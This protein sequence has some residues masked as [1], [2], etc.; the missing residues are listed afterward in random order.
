MRSDAAGRRCGP[1]GRSLIGRPTESIIEPCALPS[2]SSAW[3]TRQS[4]E[5]CSRRTL[6]PDDGRKRSSTPAR[7]LGEAVVSGAVNPDHFVVDTATGRILERRIGDKRLAIRSK[8]GG[9]TEHIAQA[10]G[11]TEACLADDQIRALAALG[12]RVETHYGSPQDTE[13]ALDGSGVFWL[14][15]AR[16]DHDAVPAARVRAAARAGPSRLLLLQRCAG[17]LSADHPDGTCGF[18]LDGFG[19]I[20]A[21]RLP[22][23]GPLEGPEPVRRG[24]TASLCGRHWRPA[25]QVRPGGVPAGSR[26]HGSA[27]GGHPSTASRPIPVFQSSTDRCCRPSAGFCASPHATESP[28]RLCV[29]WSRPTARG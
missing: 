4:Q 19:R 20:G 13:W 8:S 9:G 26:R 28:S 15:Q 22:R 3:S 5:F 21:P 14:T 1:T 23:H 18:P 29:L 25:E 12:D 7:G 2:S 16:P 17:T 10:T 27:F 11:A 24:R 6:L